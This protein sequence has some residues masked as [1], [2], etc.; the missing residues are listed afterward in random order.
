MTGDGLRVAVVGAGMHARTTVYPAMNAARY[1]VEAVA[2][3][4]IDTASVLARRHGG[5]AFDDVERML[6]KVG[7]NIEAIVM[8]LPANGYDEALLK[9]L[10][11]G[12]PVYCEK[13][14]ALHSATLR[15]FEE[16]RCATGQ[17]FMVGYQKRFAPAHERTR[18]L[19]RADEFGGAT[20]YQAYWG[21]G[22]GF[23]QD[24]DYFMR[25]NAVHHVDLARYLMG[26]V[27]DLRI[28]TQ[29]PSA[30]SM[31]AGLLMR[32]ESGAVGTLQLNTNSAW[33]H[34]NE[35]ITVAGRGSVVLVDNIETCIHRVPGEAE[36]RWVPNYTVPS[37][38]NS[39]LTVTGFTGAFQHFTEVVRNK[40]ACRSDLSSAIR[41]ME[42]VEAAIAGATTAS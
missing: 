24:F 15:R 3:R 35:W 28:F 12:L 22:A 34:N 1:V 21:M 14:V 38:A 36:R 29:I 33:D 4:S 10:P 42:L 19:I 25:E 2:T 20:A 37:P 16:I 32:F 9:C 17:P 7:S 13:P 5:Q 41:T 40:E 39:S 26:E 11:S 6:D 18:A 27:I 8:I 30:T 23:Y 31:A